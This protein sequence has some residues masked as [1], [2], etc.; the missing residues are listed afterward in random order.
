M[1]VAN[2]SLFAYRELQN[3]GDKQRRVWEVINKLQP[4]HNK[5]IADHLGWEINRVTGRVNELHEMKMIDFEKL[6][7][8]PTGRTVKFWSIRDY[9]DESLRRISNEK[10]Y[11]QD[12][13][14]L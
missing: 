1:T 3:M 9:N 14:K 13:V 12:G 4:C 6:G 5:Q 10:A 11:D 2:T 7:T 8:S